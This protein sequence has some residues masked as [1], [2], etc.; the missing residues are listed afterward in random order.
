M[1]RLSLL[2]LF[3][4][5]QRVRRDVRAVARG[6]IMNRIFNRGV[7]AALRRVRPRLYR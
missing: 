1:A 7:S 4:K 6:R 2:K 3:F 5:V